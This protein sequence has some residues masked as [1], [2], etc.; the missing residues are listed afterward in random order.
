MIGHRR[1]VQRLGWLAC[2]VL[3]MTAC[4]TSPRPVNCDWRL[5]PINRPAPKP[6]AKASKVPA[7]S[8]PISAP[9]ELR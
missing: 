2:I 5:E 6:A 8:Q 1:V 3:A 7:T 4:S 9:K